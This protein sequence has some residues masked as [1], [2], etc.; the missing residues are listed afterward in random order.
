MEVPTW[1]AYNSMIEKSNPLTLVTTLP[2]TNGS[3]TEW[4]D[5]YTAIRMANDLRSWSTFAHVTCFI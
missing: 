4:D 2:I 1:A 3:P 5:L